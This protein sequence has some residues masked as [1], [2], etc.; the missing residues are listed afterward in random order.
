[1][2]SFLP[3]NSGLPIHIGT[4]VAECVVHRNDGKLIRRFRNQQYL[5]ERLAQYKAQI[6]MLLYDARDSELKDS[7][8]RKNL[9]KLKKVEQKLLKT[10]AKID[11]LALKSRKSAHSMSQKEMNSDKMML[12]KNEEEEKVGSTSLTAKPASQSR[13]FCCCCCSN[14]GEKYIADSNGQSN[15]SPDKQTGDYSSAVMGFVT[16]EYNE[17]FARCLEDYT[18]FGSFPMSL[19]FPGKLRFKGR[20]LH[21]KRAPEPDQ[22][23][24]ENLEVGSLTLNFRLLDVLY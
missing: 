21:V 23:I 24:W 17:S 9:S 15:K 10:A 7:K 5:M 3:Q 19:F 14:S 4:W 1:M 2:Y 11:R 22:I 6:K 13:R 8:K 12:I 16:F 18:R 20:K